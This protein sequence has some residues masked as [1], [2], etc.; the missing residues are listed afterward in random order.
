M[1]E[2]LGRFA[3]FHSHLI[4]GVDDGSRTVAEAVDGVRMMLDAGISRIVTTPHIKAS[5]LDHAVDAEEYLGRVSAGFQS[6]RDALR[7]QRVRVDFEQ[8]YEVRLDRPDCD[9]SD[10]RLR[11]AGTSFVLV[12]WP[13][14]EISDETDE[15][16]TTVTAAGF[17]PVIAHPER[18]RAIE[19][20]LPALRRWRRAGAYLQVTYGSLSGRYGSAVRGAAFLLL[21]EGLVDY[22]ATDFHAR[23]GYRLHMREAVAELRAIGGDEQL[24][25]LGVT[26][27]NRLLD[28]LEPLTAP[29]LRAEREPEGRTDSTLGPL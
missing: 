12:E 23:E 20:E 27:P 25:V 3:D 8:G 18:Y 26:N 5:L 15:V 6:V 4:P 11:L 9:F 24:E 28:D 16:L 21:R 2:P 22:L 17:R 7:V 19:T 1:I 13:R 10:E 14:F 29:P